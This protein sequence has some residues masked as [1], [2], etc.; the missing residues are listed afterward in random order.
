[1]PRSTDKVLAALALAFGLTTAIPAFAQDGAAGQD[2]ISVNSF[3]GAY[4]AARAAEV[5]NDVN[6]AIAYYQR[7]LAFNPTDEA[8]QQSLMVLLISRGDF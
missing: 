2:R 5:D 7:A 4:L 1:M 8:I 3:A 6:R